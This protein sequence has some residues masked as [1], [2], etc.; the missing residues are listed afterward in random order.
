MMSVRVAPGAVFQAGSP[1]PLFRTEILG[2]PFQNGLIRNEYAV[3]RD[4]QRF[5][6]NQ[7]VDGSAVYAIR[8]LLNW[9]SLLTQ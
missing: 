8:V 4:G 2:A 5:L 9:R 1:T 6:I 7:P 3:T